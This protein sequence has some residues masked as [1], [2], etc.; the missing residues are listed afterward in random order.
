MFLE[1]LH[2]V[3]LFFLFS[4]LCFLIGFLAALEEQRRREKEKREEEE[5]QRRY[6]DK[7]SP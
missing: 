5:F 3:E 2:C 6:D 1:I 7:F 4:I